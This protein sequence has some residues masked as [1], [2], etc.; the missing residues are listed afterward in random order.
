MTRDLGYR[1]GPVSLRG[2]LAYEEVAAPKR[3]GVLVVHEGLGLN[4]HATE[5]VRMV[6]KLGYVAL[7]ADMFGDRRHVLPSGQHRLMVG[8]EVVHR[9]F[10]SLPGALDQGADLQ[11]VN[12]S[13]IDQQAVI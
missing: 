3:P 9:K 13:D 2:Y 6:A 4:D 8:R 7:A 1:D 5:R 12:N 11:A 10:R